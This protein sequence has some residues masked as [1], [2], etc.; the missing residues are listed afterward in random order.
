MTTEMQAKV[1]HTQ[2][3]DQPISI[4]E[5]AITLLPFS[6]HK[7]AKPHSHLTL[8]HLFLLPKYQQKLKRPSIIFQQSV[9]PLWWLPCHYCYEAPSKS[10]FILQETVHY[11]LGSALERNGWHL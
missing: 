1:Q 2:E 6:P 9:N 3:T 8:T 7:A 5:V 4:E 11:L 10:A